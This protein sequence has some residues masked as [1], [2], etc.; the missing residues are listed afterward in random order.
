MSHNQSV[1]TFGELC[2]AGD[3]PRN[4]TNTGGAVKAYPPGQGQ[5]GVGAGDSLMGGR[6]GTSKC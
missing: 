6:T 3:R 1:A 2:C 4:H 5:G